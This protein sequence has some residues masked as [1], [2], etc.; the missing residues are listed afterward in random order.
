MTCGSCFKC[1]EVKVRQQLLAC[2]SGLPTLARRN[3]YVVGRRTLMDRTFDQGG[4]PWPPVDQLR[5]SDRHLP[6][7][8]VRDR[9]GIEM[10]VREGRAVESKIFLT[11]IEYPTPQGPH[12]VIIPMFR[13]M[14]DKEF[15]RD[16][17][18]WLRPPLV[19]L[20]RSKRPT[21]QHSFTQSKN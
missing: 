14:I 9:E 16:Q 18:E 7:L 6:V 5:R 2:F 17:I 13:H 3:T 11:F 20:P 8:H 19:K 21:R 4:P 15:H 10:N 12:Q 1:H